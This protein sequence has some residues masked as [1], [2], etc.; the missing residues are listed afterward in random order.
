METTTPKRSKGLKGLKS[1]KS[2]HP[3]SSRFFDDD[4]REQVM[5]ID[6]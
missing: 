2:L 4:R 5:A 6:S 3:C 1:L